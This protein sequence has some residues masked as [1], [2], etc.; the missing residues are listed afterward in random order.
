MT[1]AEE[2]TDHFDAELKNFHDNRSKPVPKNRVTD[3]PALTMK[4]FE[5]IVHG[6]FYIKKFMDD[7]QSGHIRAQ[8]DRDLILL[9][10]IKNCI[11]SQLISKQ[12]LFPVEA[13]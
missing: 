6:Q 12:L 9:D 3:G 4:H 11:T 7:F 13:L 2:L 1:I 5:A 8:V 10:E